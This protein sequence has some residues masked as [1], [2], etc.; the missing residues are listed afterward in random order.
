MKTQRGRQ[1]RL[2]WKAVWSRRLPART[3]DSPF[4]LCRERR[5]MRTCSLSF[6]NSTSWT[7]TAMLPLVVGAHRDSH[8]RHRSALLLNTFI[9]NNH[10]FR[11]PSSG[12]SAKIRLCHPVSVT[13]WNLLKYEYMGVRELN[14]IR[15]V[16]GQTHTH[17]FDHDC[18]HSA[19]GCG[20]GVTRGNIKVRASTDDGQHGLRNRFCVATWMEICDH[21][22]FSCG[23][24]RGNSTQTSAGRCSTRPSMLLPHEYHVRLGVENRGV[25]CHLARS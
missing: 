14:P 8:Q 15:R 4:N 5:F 16:S 13:D 19:S 1:R 2:Q 6:S 3:A 11:F 12:Q 25:W 9:C 22:L 20:F 17:S 18:H 7:T 23:K 10:A 21:E 24:Q